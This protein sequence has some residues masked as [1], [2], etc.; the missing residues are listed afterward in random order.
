[1]EFRE[2]MIRIGVA[3]L[4]GTMIGVEREI[5]NRP[6]GMRTHVL[7]CLGACMIASLECSLQI[8]MA[9]DASLHNVSMTRGREERIFTYEDG[10]QIWW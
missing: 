2:M 1:M 7:V 8:K 5:K 4:I 3:V 9:L 10:K 6:A